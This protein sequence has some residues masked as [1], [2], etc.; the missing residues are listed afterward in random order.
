ME[1]TDALLFLTGTV[2]AIVVLFEGRTG[3][4]EGS[5]EGCC[6]TVFIP[7]NVVVA[8]TVAFAC[9]ALPFLDA[10]IVDTLESR[11][12]NLPLDTAPLEASLPLDCTLSLVA[13]PPNILLLVMS[14][15]A[16]LFRR[17]ATPPAE[18]LGFVEALLGLRGASS[19]ST[20]ALRA[21]A[22]ILRAA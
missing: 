2:V 18:E 1:D 14:T 4:S 7:C 22:G 15:S 10:P 8:D 9:I 13:A 17:A 16:V 6:L 11:T 3:L 20:R 21:L 12:A 5:A 19:R